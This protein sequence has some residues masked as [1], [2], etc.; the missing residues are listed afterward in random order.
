[1]AGRCALRYWTLRSLMP[2]SGC[3]ARFWII[4]S[5]VFARWCVSM[6]NPSWNRSGCSCPVWSSA[7]RGAIVTVASVAGFFPLPY[8][9]EYAATKAFLI[10]F[11][12]AVAE[13]VRPFGVRLQV[14]CPGSTETDF[15][16]TAGFRPRNPLRRHTAEAVV[17]AS[18]RGLRRRRVVV[19][20]GAGG[21]LLRVLSRCV[22]ASL[23]AKAAALWLRE[24]GRRT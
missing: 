23:I 3:S 19:T 21:A 8:M 1:M 15:H 6:W 11:T 14:C 16:T 18:L 7:G 10:S 2:G 22:P 13:E 5:H 9:A 12:Q 24:A 4:R 20:V 17:A